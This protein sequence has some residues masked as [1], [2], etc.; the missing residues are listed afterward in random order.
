[1][2]ARLQNEREASLHGSARRQWLEGHG[3]K[4]EGTAPNGYTKMYSS[5]EHPPITGE[6]TAAG[7]IRTQVYD[8]LEAAGSIKRQRRRA[9]GTTLQG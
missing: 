7:A 4:Y 9:Y 8:S 6:L 1:M 3:W 5:P 2:L